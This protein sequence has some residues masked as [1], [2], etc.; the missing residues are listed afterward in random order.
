MYHIKSAKHKIDQSNHIHGAHMKVY[1]KLT[2]SN[3]EKLIMGISPNPVKCG[4]GLAIGDGKV[5]PEIN[6]TLP[7][8][9]IT[10][11]TMEEVRKHYSEMMENILARM[12]PDL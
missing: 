2:I 5:F 4:N 11:E 7:T 8:M 6:F 9:L 12:L 1:N 10:K 3:H